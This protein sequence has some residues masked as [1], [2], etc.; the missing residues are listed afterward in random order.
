MTLLLL[1]CATISVLAGR[2]QF[3]PLNTLLLLLVMFSLFAI[4]ACKSLGLL[5]P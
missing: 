1:L 4:Y 5:T 2:R 3:H